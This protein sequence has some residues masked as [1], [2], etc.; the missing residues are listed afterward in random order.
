MKTSNSSRH[1]KGDSIASHKAI[2]NDTVEKDRSPPESERVSLATRLVPLST[3]TWK[4]QHSLVI[5]TSARSFKKSNMPRLAELKQDKFWPFSIMLPRPQS[6][7]REEKQN[8][9]KCIYANLSDQR[10]EEVSDLSLCLG[11][12][13]SANTQLSSRAKAKGDTT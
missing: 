13:H 5:T 8:Q 12:K 6:N 9:A 10:M 4:S 7:Q 2:M 3:F 11:L 1:L